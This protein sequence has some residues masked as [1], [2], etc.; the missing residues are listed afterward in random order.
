[1]KYLWTNKQSTERRWQWSSGRGTKQVVEIPAVMDGVLSTSCLRTTGLLNRELLR[2]T[3]YT[4]KKKMT[5]P[6]ILSFS[7]LLNGLKN[8]ETHCPVFTLTI[9]TEERRH[10]EKVVSTNL[11]PCD[12]TCWDSILHLHVF[13]QTLLPHQWH[14][15]SVPLSP[16]S[17]VQYNHTLRSLRLD[18]WNLNFPWPITF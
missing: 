1:M 9:Q 3:I 18:S 11:G 5:T 16:Y 12:P 14:V 15:P 6:L 4:N 2:R 17:D 10:S 7:D 13:T 8:D